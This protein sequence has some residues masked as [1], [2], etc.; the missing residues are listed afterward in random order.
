MTRKTLKT[1]A[2]AAALAATVAS[3]AATAY[4]A[5]SV[6]GS[7]LTMGGPAYADQ[8]LIAVD[9]APAAAPNATTPASR[10]DIQGTGPR[11]AQPGPIRAFR[12]WL[13]SLPR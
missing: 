4:F 7:A 11:P 5:V 9:P 3:P 8:R 1:L 10:S 12:R 13:D 2:A 6:P